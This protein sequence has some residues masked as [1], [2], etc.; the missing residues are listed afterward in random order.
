MTVHEAVQDTLREALEHANA[1]GTHI[2]VVHGVVG[3]GSSALLEAFAHM[4]ARGRRPR[5]RVL[6]LQPSPTEPYRPFTHAALASRPTLYRR[7]G[8]ERQARD[9]ARSL[10]V[11][12]LGA[13]P[14]WGDLIG[15]IGATAEALRRRRDAHGLP[16]LAVTENVAAALWVAA[17]RRTLVLCIDDAER[18]SAADLKLLVPLLREAPATARLLV[19]AACDAARLSTESPLHP[20]ADAL[21]GARHV[22]LPAPDHVPAAELGRIDARTHAV[23]RRAA[24]LDE[25]FAAL[26]LA[27]LLHVDHLEVEDR[28]AIA[29]RARLVAYA[30]DI[31]APAPSSTFRLASARVRDQLML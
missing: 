8:G 19:V 23:L 12:W 17:R 21:P 14:G 22:E 27:R 3:A 13:V 26:E 18:M 16:R 15:A 2:V 11:E 7:L 20:D 5:P 10:A 31:D 4:A 1:G 6:L 25:P 28:L 30:G 29:E 24:T 9:V